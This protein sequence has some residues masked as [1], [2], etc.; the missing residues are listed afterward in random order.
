MKTF[1][2]LNIQRRYEVKMNVM[3]QSHCNVLDNVSQRVK[4]APKTPVHV[5]VGF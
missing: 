1:L 5:G 3:G 2:T 4:H